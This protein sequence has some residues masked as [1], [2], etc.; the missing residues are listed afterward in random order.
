M[1]NRPWTANYLK[2]HHFHL[3][4]FDLPV[5]IIGIVAQYCDHVIL[6][7]DEVARI[8]KLNNNI[9]VDD[10]GVPLCLRH[11]VLVGDLI[12]EERWDSDRPRYHIVASPTRLIEVGGADVWGL[13]IPWK[14]TRHF[15]DITTKMQRIVKKYFTKLRMR[16]DD[17]WIVKRV[18]QLPDDWKFQWQSNFLFDPESLKVSFPM[19]GGGYSNH[20]SVFTEFL[21][22]ER[23]FDLS[24]SID[25]PRVSFTVDVSCIRN[26]ITEEA[27]LEKEMRRF[28]KPLPASLIPHSWVFEVEFI[29]RKEKKNHQF[30]E[31]TGFHYKIPMRDKV[32]F[33]NVM[34][35]YNWPPKF[36]KRELYWATLCDPIYCFTVKEAFGF[37]PS[38]L[39]RL[40]F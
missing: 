28:I 40:S 7:S 2:T 32:A 39:E 18:G 17:A 13:E 4:T 23:L 37:Q 24:K 3:F 20:Y 12:L 8:Y 33:F 15:K 10:H 6:P 27:L 11:R 29:Y 5:D 30:C 25:E 34:Q 16:H 38:F 31:T 26:E 19:T 36:T 35:R 1:L 14:V 21:T 9:S 22:R